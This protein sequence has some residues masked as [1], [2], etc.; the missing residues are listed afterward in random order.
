MRTDPVY[1][2]DY[3]MAFHNP[4]ASG[5]IVNPKSLGDEH[6]GLEG[7]D[8]G[9]LETGLRCGRGATC[10][11]W[12]WRIRPR[13]RPESVLADRAYD[14]EDKIRKPLRERG[15]QP[16]IAKRNTV[17]GSGLGRHRCVVEAAF[18]W[19][20]KYRRLRV[21]YEKRDDIHE[22]FLKIACFLICW[23]RVFEFC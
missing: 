5:R 6:G 11:T 23:N 17:H 3:N 16:L 13:K 2:L 19:L 18:A 15:I 22:A 12:P 14:A 20:F 8:A 10:Q 4:L 7:G 9:R 1:L 21:R